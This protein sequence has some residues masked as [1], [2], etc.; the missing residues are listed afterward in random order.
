MAHADV[1]A[2]WRALRQGAH[3]R[4]QEGGIGSAPRVGH[5]T[6]RN[7][8]ELKYDATEAFTP[9]YYS[10]ERFLRDQVDADPERFVAIPDG[11]PLADVWPC[12]AVDQFGAWIHFRPHGFIPAAYQVH[13]SDSGPDQPGPPPS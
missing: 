10:G 12:H 2:D 7:E 11:C 3:V 5:N 1:D 13:G 8:L 9:D 6:P 4:Y